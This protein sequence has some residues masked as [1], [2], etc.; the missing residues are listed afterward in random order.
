MFDRRSWVTSTRS[1]DTI[2]SFTSRQGPLLS[3]RNVDV[4]NRHCIP[5]SV[6]IDILFSVRY[7]EKTT[8]QL[9]KFDL[10]R[11]MAEPAVCASAMTPQ[12]AAYE[13]ERLIAEANS[14][15]LVYYILC[16]SAPRL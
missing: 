15:C 5:T 3:L 9:G 6:I 12:D 14:A 8:S 13:T 2:S 11:K 4:S 1:Y 7:Y 10:F 16:H